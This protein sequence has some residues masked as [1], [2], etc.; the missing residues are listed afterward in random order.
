MRLS[1][2]IAKCE[3]G[4]VTLARGTKNKAQDLAF[5]LKC[6]SADFHL[7]VLAHQ[8]DQLQRS[9]AKLSNVD[10]AEIEIRAM[11]LAALRDAAEIRKA[12][13]RLRAQYAAMV[14]DGTIP[15]DILSSGVLT[16]SPLPSSPSSASGS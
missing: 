13:R 11:D 4:F 5:T 12:E 1:H 10:K 14:K 9:M 2:L 3:N 8:Q 16:C 7:E 15:L 6:K